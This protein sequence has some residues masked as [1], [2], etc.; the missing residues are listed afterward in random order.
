VTDF[1][2]TIF[3]APVANVLILCG[4]GFLF[5]GLIGKISGKIDPG[6]VSR[7]LSSSVGIALIVTGLIM[8]GHTRPDQA[9]EH[10]DKSKDAAP[11]ET[12]SVTNKVT[13]PPQSPSA[14]QAAVRPVNN[15]PISRRPIQTNQSP[16]ST[17]ALHRPP[18]PPSQSA[19]VQIASNDWTETGLYVRA[20]Q[21]VVIRAMGQWNVWPGVFPMTG[22]AGYPNERD[23]LVEHHGWSYDDLHAALPLPTAPNGALIGRVGSQVFFVGPRFEQRINLP[24]QLYLGC[25]DIDANNVG[26]MSANITLRTP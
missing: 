9:N 4:L 17:N 13:E 24:G 25:N 15:T 16:L 18:P 2:K 8:Y 22:P 26:S 20:G 7:I 1:V 10:A 3:G 6:Q 12:S 19:T 11:I 23:L 5:V 21:E 14:N